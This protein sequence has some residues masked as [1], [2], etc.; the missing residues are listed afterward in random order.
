MTLQILLSFIIEFATVIDLNHA[1]AIFVICAV[2][3]FKFIFIRFTFSIVFRHI[4]IGSVLLNIYFL[5]Y[6]EL[7]DDGF[8]T[9]GYFAST[10]FGF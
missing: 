1:F 2:F 7:K 3:F 4:L 5:G 10:S 8:S 9:K 6:L